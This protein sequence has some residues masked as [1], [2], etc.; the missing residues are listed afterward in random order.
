MSEDF[1]GSEFSP[2]GNASG[3][4]NF[5]FDKAASTFPDID[6]L[7]GDVPQPPATSQPTTN[8]FSFSSF[9]PAREV[10]VTSNDEFDQ[11]ESNFPEL[12]EQKVGL[13][14]IVWFASR[15]H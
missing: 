14:C 12:D 9:E 11:F 3:M 5:D 7:E 2:S 13:I 6:G 4:D 10:M 15:S 8:G 1:L